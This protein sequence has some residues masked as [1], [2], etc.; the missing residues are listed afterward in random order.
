MSDFCCRCGKDRDKYEE[1]VATI[2]AQLNYPD[3]KRI[4]LT[5]YLCEKCADEAL[6][7]MEGKA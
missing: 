1:A 7:I 4:H 6:E 3:G 5:Y 2:K